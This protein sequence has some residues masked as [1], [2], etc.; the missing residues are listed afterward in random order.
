MVHRC[1]PA[2]SALGRLETAIAPTANRYDLIVVDSPPGD[3]ALQTVAAR[4]A[5]VVIVPTRWVVGPLDKK[6]TEQTNS[7][8]VSRSRSISVSSRQSA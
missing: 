8:Q 7:S 3:R 6:R 2:L 5:R 4:A 1:L